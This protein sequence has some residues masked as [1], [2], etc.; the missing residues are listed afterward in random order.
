M[1]TKIGNTRC[2]PIGHFTVN[3]KRCVVYTT[4]TYT[5]LENDS[6]T[7]KGIT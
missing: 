1:K 2:F 7:K 6:G 4:V 5:W 3:R